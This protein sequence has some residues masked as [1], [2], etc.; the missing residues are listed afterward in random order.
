W[1]SFLDRTNVTVIGLT[2]LFNLYTRSAGVAYFTV[3]AVGCSLS[4]KVIKKFVR[5]PRPPPLVHVA[6][7][8]KRVKVTYGMPSTHSA[9]ISYF[10]TYI[11]L[12]CLYLPTHPSLFPAG[13]L[14]RVLLPL[15][16]LPWG[17]TIMMS[18]VWLGH[19]TWPQVFA[20]ASY[21]AF[22]AL[23]WFSLWTK[24]G[25]NEVGGELER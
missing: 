16:T 12:A 21:G 8:K 7:R 10:M 25:L 18:R 6:G 4:V 3:G 5:Q 14:I 20:G 13:N 24:W 22:V 23:A 15:I 11:A 19:H 2:A 9:S 1:L 17:V